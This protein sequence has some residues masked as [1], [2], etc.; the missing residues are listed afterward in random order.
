MLKAPRPGQVKTR[1]ARTIGSEQATKGY[2][3]LVEHQIRQIPGDWKIQI[4]FTPA[5]ATEEMQSWLGPSHTYREQPD[6][7]RGQRLFMAMETH[8]ATS[9]EPLVF[10]GADCPYLTTPVLNQVRV[11]LSDTDVVLIPAL[12][13]GYCLLAL[14]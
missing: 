5:D 11:I 2:R 8:F 14:K 9:D 12:D 4:H 3:H 13:G 7:D 10:L 6:G 1:L